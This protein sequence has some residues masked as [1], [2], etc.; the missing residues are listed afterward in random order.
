MDEIGRIAED[1]DWTVMILPR[2]GRLT[3]DDIIRLY[4]TIEKVVNTG[5]SEWQI[6][7]HI[8]LKKREAFT[9]DA[10]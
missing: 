3:R 5:P 6:E 1:H 7:S 10:S 9:T 4:E 8:S 2:S